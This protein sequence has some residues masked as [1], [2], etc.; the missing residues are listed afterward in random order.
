MTLHQVTSSI[1]ARIPIATTHA[2]GEQRASLSGLENSWYPVIP[3]RFVYVTMFGPRV[4]SPGK[5]AFDGLLWDGDAFWQ[6]RR[7]LQLPLRRVERR[8]RGGAHCESQ[9]RVTSAPVSLRHATSYTI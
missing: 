6:A 3:S 1:E 4:A 2:K 5:N 7:G 9:G 8:L